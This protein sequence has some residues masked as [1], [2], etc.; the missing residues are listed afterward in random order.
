MIWRERIKGGNLRV[1]GEK[2]GRKE[3]K[4][5]GEKTTWGETQN[6]LDFLCKGKSM[7]SLQILVS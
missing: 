3:K 4:K 1:L 5:R 2:G 7:P 6:L